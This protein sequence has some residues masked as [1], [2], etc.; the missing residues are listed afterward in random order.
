MDLVSP[1][2]IRFW[3]YINAFFFIVFITK[4]SLGIF[5]LIT[6]LIILIKKFI[7]KLSGPS[8]FNPS[9]NQFIRNSMM[10]VGFLPFPGLFYGM[11]RNPYRYKVFRSNIP[12]KGLT[13]SLKD[14]KIVQISDIHSGSWVFRDP[15][16]RAVE[17]INELN[18]DLVV[19]T[20]DLVNNRADEMIPFVDIFSKIE[21]RYGVYS[22]LGNHDYGDYF[23]WISP[24]SKQAN[25]EKLKSI[26]AKMGWKLLM[27]ESRLV[28]TSG[29]GRISVTGVENYSALPQF[30]KYGSLKKAT[31]DLPESD[32]RIVLSHDPTHWDAEINTF[33]IPIDLTL[34]GHTHGFQFGLEIPGWVKW[35]PSSLVYN[36]WAGLYRKGEKNLYVNRGLGFLGYPGRLGILPEIGLL[37]LKSY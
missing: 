25:F 6:E 29:G 4:L 23:S 9:R 7:T 35:S 22:V 10:L 37:T 26:H 30:Q 32:I 1:S 17:M 27:N 31:V 34:S 3:I 14:F 33:H 20:G 5:G 15:V 8:K 13:D 19:F 36:Q 18:P 16:V 12:I 24:E 28:T 2:E 11:I 21:S